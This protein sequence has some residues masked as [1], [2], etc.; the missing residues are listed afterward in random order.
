[1]LTIVAFTLPCLGFLVLGYLMHEAFKRDLAKT[2]AEHAA[3]VE[4]IHD[5]WQETVDSVQARE[6]DTIIELGE[7]RAHLA[8]AEQQARD[9]E[10][11]LVVADAEIERLTLG[12]P[13]GEVLKFARGA[14]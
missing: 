3:N 2:K 7:A 8:R 12:Q 4:E 6:L 13:S 10:L 11:M 9:N 5:A 1:M 14:R